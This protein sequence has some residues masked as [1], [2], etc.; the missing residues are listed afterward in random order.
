[1]DNN[2]IRSLVQAD[3]SRPRKETW[4]GTGEQKN[5]IVVP[6]HIHLGGGGE[7]CGGEG[8]GGGGGL[9]LIM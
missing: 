4:R 5:L 3:K 7:G 6:I 1:M 8:G 2:E 9:G